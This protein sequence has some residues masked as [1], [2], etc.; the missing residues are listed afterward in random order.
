MA[1]V[2]RQNLSQVISAELLER[3]RSGLV[4]PGDRLPTEQ[5]LMTEFGVGRNVIREAVQHLVALDVVN[6]RPRRGIVVTEHGPVSALDSLAM[7][8]LLNDQ[9]VHDLYAFRLLLETE[10]AEAAARRASPEDL[11]AIETALDRFRVSLG[12]QTGMF[13][14]DVNFHEQL[15][16]ASGNVIYSRVL[17]ALSGLLEL[18]RRE[19][20]K[21]PGAPERALVQH[22]AIVDAIR[23]GD[24]DRARAAMEQHLRTAIA[25]VEELPLLQRRADAAETPEAPKTAETVVSD[26]G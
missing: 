21:V 25:A 10:I 13:A 15:A 14:A 4:R 7:G 6:V 19:T 26:A 18:Y 22:T 20:D 1:E 5:G 23:D 3:I 17:A 8:A 9:T 2:R 11:V 12:A 24:P 16:Q